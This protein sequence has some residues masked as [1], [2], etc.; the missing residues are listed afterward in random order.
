MPACDD[1]AAAT[2]TQWKGGHCA[3]DEP[4][5]AHDTKLRTYLRPYKQQ[6]RQPIHTF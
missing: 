2:R 1:E 5:Y 6:R 3:H 4:V